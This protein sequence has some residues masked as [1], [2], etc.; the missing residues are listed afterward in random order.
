LTKPIFYHVQKFSIHSLRTELYF[1]ASEGVAVILF[2]RFF[3][4]ML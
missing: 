1:S 4:F 3:N 2:I